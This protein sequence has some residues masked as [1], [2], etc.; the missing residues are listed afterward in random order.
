MSISVALQ[1][2]YGE[3]ICLPASRGDIMV[4]AGVLDGAAIT[5]YTN[6]QCLALA[7]SFH[8]RFEWP[9]IAHL[10]R[11]GDLQWET[12]LNGGLDNA[13]EEPNWFFDFVHVLVEH[14]SGELVDING[15]HDRDNYLA[16]AADTYGTAALV[17]VPAEILIAA[18]AEHAPATRQNLDCAAAFV[19]AI[20]DANTLI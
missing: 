20:V 5:A 17:E 2:T 9:L 7:L 3:R 12:R 13:F 6:G 16:C 8:H 14:P 1:P 4:R 11:P 10:C 15:I 18:F 19:D